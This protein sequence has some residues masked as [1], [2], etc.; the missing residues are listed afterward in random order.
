MH[1][2]DLDDARDTAH[3]VQESSSY[4]FLVRG[5]LVAFGVVHLLVGYLA[6]RLALGSSGED[7]SQSGA[8]RELAKAPMGPV[9]L[10]AV[11]VGL[12]VIALWQL[13]SAFVGHRHLSGKLRSRRRLVSVGRTVLYG[14][15]AVNAAIIAMGG[16][17]GDGGDTVSATLLSLP[18]GRFMI[19]IVGVSVGAVGVSQVLR[20]ARDKYKDE[21]QGELSVLQRWIARVGHVGKGAAIMV[22]GALFIWAA[23]TYDSNSA[24]GLD[25]ALQIVRTGPFG[26]I[27][28]FAIA[29]GFACYGTYAFIWARHARFH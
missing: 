1:R 9:L 20:G 8:L 11:T 19:I 24:G 4:R 6:V 27:A 5:G 26:N 17:G 7:A 21:L 12:F 14:V 25:N 3:K 2:P 23:W 15:L 16:N 28:L 29:L 13:L 10:W 18:F 22:V